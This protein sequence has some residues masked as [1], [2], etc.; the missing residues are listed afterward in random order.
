MAVVSKVRFHLFII[1]YLSRILV[2]CTLGIKREFLF[3][4]T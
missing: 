2:H 3:N 4:I 1:E